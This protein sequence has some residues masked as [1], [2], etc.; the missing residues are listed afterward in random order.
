[1]SAG[2]RRAVSAP[3]APPASKAALSALA[4]PPPAAHQKPIGPSSPLS[5]TSHL[6]K[7]HA[8]SDLLVGCVSPSLLPVSPP[9][10]RRPR[11]PSVP[12]VTAGLPAGLSGATLAP[13]DALVCV[14]VRSPP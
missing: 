7:R 5:L 8:P 4:A 3:R 13:S 12:V 10:P 11:L 1:M 14:A 2:V 9:P 6:S